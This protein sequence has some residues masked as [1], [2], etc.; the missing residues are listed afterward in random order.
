MLAVRE[1]AGWR[2]QLSDEVKTI[3]LTRAKCCEIIAEKYIGKGQ[4]PSY[5]LLGLF[6][7]MDTILSIPMET[8][9]DK[10]PL[11]DTI[12]NA[13]C[14][15]E[16]EMRGVLELVISIEKGEWEL[17]E[18]LLNKSGIDS[19]KLPSIYQQALKW[20]VNVLN[21]DYLD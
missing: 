10:L 5:F 9:L 15:E 1:N 3:C 6:S 12:Y 20:S 8:I 18:R 14:G 21:E 7:L 4:S 13:L 11:D 19:S 16:N 2:Q 17:M